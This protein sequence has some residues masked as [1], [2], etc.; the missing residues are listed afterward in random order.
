MEKEEGY[1]RETGEK[2]RR[3]NINGGKKERRRIGREGRRNEKEDEDG[4]EGKRV[5][6]LYSKRRGIGRRERR[7]RGERRTVKKNY[8]EEVKLGTD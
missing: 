6:V 1:K 8:M 5:E 4:I 2:G 3:R 7:R